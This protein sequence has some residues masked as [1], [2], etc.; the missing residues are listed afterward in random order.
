MAELTPSQSAL[1]RIPSKTDPDQVWISWHRSLIAELKKDNANY[2][3]LQAWNK[4]S[5]NGQKADTS[6]L[7]RYMS[8][9]GVNL[10]TSWFESGT[11]FFNTGLDGV[12]SIWSSFAKS[13][14][15]AGIFVAIVILI[16][17][18]AV[19]RKPEIVS[20]IVKPI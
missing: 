2:V 20:R 7:R 14:K 13:F 9:Q 4:R 5:M 8:G 17:V 11:D 1:R 6:E 16:V 3:F 18:I 19:I 12:T 10:A 15:Y